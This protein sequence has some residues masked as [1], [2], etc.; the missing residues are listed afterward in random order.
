[1]RSDPRFVSVK[2]RLWLTAGH[3]TFLGKGRVAL[4]KAIEKHGSISGAARSMNMSYL[5]AWKLVESM[6]DMSEVPLV[7]RTSGG[8]GGGGSVLTDH[9]KKMIQLFEHLHQRCEKFL[10]TEL[11]E[12]MGRTMN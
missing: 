9:G 4:L 12:F 6:N 5:K 2:N 7:I 1:M 10:K 11:K 8:K 3:Y